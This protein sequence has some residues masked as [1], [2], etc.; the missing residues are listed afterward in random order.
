[1]H[2]EDYGSW[3]RR[4]DTAV[5]PPSRPHAGHSRAGTPGAHR[6][7]WR[8]AAL[9][10]SQVG[11]VMPSSSRLGAALA[12]PVPR[13]GS[14]TIVELGPGTGAVSRQIAQRISGS[15]R[16]LAIEIDPVMAAWLQ[17]ARDDIEVVEGD[18]LDLPKILASRDVRFADAIVSS[19]PWSLFDAESQVGMLTAVS[20]SI[21]PSGSF[22][23]F[24]YVTGLWLPPARRFARLLR[25]SFDEVITTAPVWRNLPPAVVYVC[26]RPRLAEPISSSVPGG[27]VTA[28]PLHPPHLPGVLQQ[29]LEPAHR[30]G[31]NSRLSLTAPD[32]RAPGMSPSLSALVA[33]AL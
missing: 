31:V 27:S 17:A 14:P 32:S 1:M 10:Q 22:T 13:D 20:R 4:A 33:D 29:A 11:A 30:E 24:A 15:A 8:R 25:D 3:R 12:T 9:R 16:H 18:A 19:L 23:T 21:S 26:R 6:T 7:F 2:S 28:S 5:P